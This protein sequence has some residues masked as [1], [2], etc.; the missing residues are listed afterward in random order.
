MRIYRSAFCTYGILQHCFFVFGTFY[1]WL[2]DL[3]IF[4]IF[5]CTFSPVMPQLV[6]NAAT[7]LIKIAERVCHSSD[8]L[9]ELS[10][11]G[12]IHQAIHL[13]NVNC[14]TTLCQPIYSV[15]SLLIS[16]LLDSCF[17]SYCVC[18]S[19]LLSCYW[20]A[21]FAWVACQ[22]CFWFRC[23]CQDSFRA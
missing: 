21:G 17:I 6:E 16:F 2:H 11:H 9:D 12:L 13:V 8:M 23:R 4:L 20:F 10:K 14:R 7:C 18:L 19:V 15:C 3:T 1:T 5:S 22:T